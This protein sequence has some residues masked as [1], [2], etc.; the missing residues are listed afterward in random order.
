MPQCEGICRPPEFGSSLAPTRLQEHFQRRDAQHQAKRAIAIVGKHPIVAR[1]Q[2]Q[3]RGGQYAFMPRAAD[4]EKSFVLAFQLNFAV[5]DAPRKKHGA[6]NT[7]KIPPGQVLDTG[8]ES[9]FAV[10]G[11]A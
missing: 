11:R 1:T 3:T 8:L 7:K 2:N 6:V 5:I 9:I 10:L 4:L